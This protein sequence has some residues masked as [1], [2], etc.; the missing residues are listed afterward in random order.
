MVIP[1]VRVS[2]CS[3]KLA[4]LALVQIEDVAA[5]L[6]HVSAAVIALDILRSSCHCI[7]DTIAGQVTTLDQVLQH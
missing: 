5:D 7:Q 1:S 4:P 6:L 3:S 2:L